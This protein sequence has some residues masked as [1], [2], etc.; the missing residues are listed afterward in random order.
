MLE[1]P[2]PPVSHNVKAEEAA[3]AVLSAAKYQKKR[4]RVPTSSQ[5]V[6][7]S[8][9][10]AQRSEVWRLMRRECSG[11]SWLSK[12]WKSG[13]KRGDG[14]AGFNG[15]WGGDVA[16]EL[17]AS[18]R[19]GRRTCMVDEIGDLYTYTFNWNGCQEENNSLTKTMNTLRIR[20][21]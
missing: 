13:E 3:G 1:T 21:R 18:R 19:R 20:Y 14:F 17:L 12:T 15:F 10:V 16:M 5:P 4:C 2:G 7:C 8:T 9:G 6:Y 11:E